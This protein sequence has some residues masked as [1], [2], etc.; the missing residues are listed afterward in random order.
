MAVTVPLPLL[1]ALVS[2]SFE[3]EL[4]APS[5]AEVVLTCLDDQRPLVATV[6]ARPHP[7]VDWIKTR[8]DTE[9]ILLTED[10]RDRVPQELAEKLRPLVERR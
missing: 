3:L 8:P 7:F 9:V 6:M 1:C 2:S 4:L 5:F 10:N